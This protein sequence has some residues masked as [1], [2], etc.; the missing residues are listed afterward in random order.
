[1]G[2]IEEFTAW[3]GDYCVRIGAKGD[4]RMHAETFTRSYTQGHRHY[5]T[6][7]HIMEMHE[8]FKRAPMPPSHWV[9]EY[10]IMAHDLIYFPGK[11]DCEERSAD[12]A[13]IIAQKLHFP[14]TIIDQ[15]SR[16]I[17]ATKRTGESMDEASR[18][19]VDLDLLILAA[20]R[21]RVIEYDD[22]IRAEYQQVYSK[23]KYDTGR[24]AVLRILGE[25]AKN[26]ALFKRDCFKHK[27]IFAEK[28]IAMLLERLEK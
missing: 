21:D 20:P 26:K 19:L 5:H 6:L 10:D 17:L 15:V 14:P 8:M 27:N 13:M 22:Q 24:K 23:D 3:F 9:V 12:D 2:D 11:K 1:M 4:I 18:H 16:P 28:N 25:R 7:R